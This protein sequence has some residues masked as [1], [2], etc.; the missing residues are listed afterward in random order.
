VERNEEDS[1]RQ[2]RW[3]PPPNGVIKVN[4]D[5]SINVAKYWVGLGIIA[6][7]NKGLCMGARSITQQ[8]RINPKTAEIMA[9]L[10]AV[11]FS[12]E[13]G[14]WDVIFEGDAAQV[15]KELT[16]HSLSF[17]KVGHFMESIQVEKQHFQLAIFQAIPR[18]CNMAAHTL[19]KEA[20]SNYVDLCC[21][22]DTPMSIV[23]R[24][25]PGP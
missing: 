4:W 21:L 1:S 10:Q 23:F 3:V 5:A 12:K 19:A 17:S 14:F 15:V 18:V 11:Q 22:E 9:A 16:T 6:R 25:Q 2:S 20:S 7:D 13:V 8:A 24:E